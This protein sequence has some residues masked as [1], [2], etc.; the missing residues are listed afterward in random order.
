VRFSLQVKWVSPDNQTFT[1]DKVRITREYDGYGRL[2]DLKIHFD[3][4][5]RYM[6]QINYDQTGRV[7]QWRRLIGQTDTQAVEYIYDI[8]SH[9][10]DVLVEGQTMWAYAYDPNGNIKKITENGKTRHLDFDVGDK[11]TLF[12]ELQYKYDD[13]GLTAQRGMDHVDFNSLGQLTTV[14]RDGGAVRFTFE[15]NVDGRLTVQRDQW[16][17][18]MQYFYGHPQKPHLVTHTFN[19]TN[20]EASV[21]IYDDRDAILAMQRSGKTYYIASDPNGTPLVIF[22]ERG[23]VVKQCSYTPLGLRLLDSK[24]NF[25]L[26]F[27]FQGAIYNDLVQLAFMG[28]RGVYDV[29]LGR[30]LSPDYAGAFDKLETVVEDPESLNLYQYRT[31]VNRHLR[32]LQNPRLGKCY[33]SAMYMSCFPFLGCIVVLVVRTK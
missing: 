12:G 21:Y 22:D 33:M 20:G 5:I 9:L 16:G 27:G 13:D 19:H 31:I 30:F 3:N 14:S 8:D 10:T 28:K 29:H 4:S 2:G 24:P 11:I 15:Y 25:D 32:H 18:I 26:P 7:H 6:L 23:Y 17:H 1:D